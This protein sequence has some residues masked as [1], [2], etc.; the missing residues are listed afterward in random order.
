MVMIPLAVINK[1][2]PMIDFPQWRK[3]WRDSIEYIRKLRV[4]VFTSFLEIDGF[5]LLVVRSLLGSVHSLDPFFLPP[6]RGWFAFAQAAAY[7]LM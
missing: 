1:G 2:N 4:L 7:R 3:S 6:L 5:S